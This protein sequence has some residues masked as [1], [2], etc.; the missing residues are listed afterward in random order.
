[1]RKKETIPKLKVVKKK[2][3]E[4][5]TSKKRFQSVQPRKNVVYLNQHPS[6]AQVQL[7][8]QDKEKIYLYSKG[9]LSQRDDSEGKDNANSPFLNSSV[10]Y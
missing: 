9:V 4:E 10:K 8:E 7:T 5:T 1:M 6:L 3:E 2:K